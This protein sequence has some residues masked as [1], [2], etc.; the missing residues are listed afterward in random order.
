[1]KEMFDAA[2]ARQGI[3][4]EWRVGSGEPSRIVALHGRYADLIILG[5]LDPN[6]GLS[7]CCPRPEDVA[8]TTGRPVLVIPY[9]GDFTT[10]G[11][12]VLVGWNTSREATRAIG[13]ALPL[14]RAAQSVTILSIDPRS[15]SEGHGAVP[16]ADIARYLARHG[17][18]AV[19]DWAVS[20]GIDAGNILL[21]R[22]ADLMADLLVI[23]AYGHPRFRELVLGGVTGL[24]SNDLVIGPVPRK[25]SMTRINAALYC[26]DHKGLIFGVGYSNTPEGAGWRYQVRGGR[27]R[28]A[29]CRDN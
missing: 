8:L 13:D 24:P 5:Q 25:P 16:G 26:G 22:A 11:Q 20:N 19:V 29:D 3:T 14:L 23:G 2:V 7:A 28:F 9:V 1:L 10:V 4:S 12:R 18:N 27:Q 17:I 21:S 15:T 6:V